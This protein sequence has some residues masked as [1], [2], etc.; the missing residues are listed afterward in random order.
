MYLAGVTD[1]AALEAEFSERA[2]RLHELAVSIGMERAK[3]NVTGVQA[4]LVPFKSIAARMS[5]INRQLTG[6]ELTAYDNFVLSTGQWIADSA[7]AGATILRDTA[8]L[9][10]DVAGS[11]ISPVVGPLIIPAIL[12]LAGFYLFTQMKA[13]R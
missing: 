8:N 4:M 9:T 5:E 12:A 10:G 2:K 11:L 3:G 13:G 1:T 7:K 6:V